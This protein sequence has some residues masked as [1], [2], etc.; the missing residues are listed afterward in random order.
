MIPPALALD[1][2]YADEVRK[3]RPWGYWRFETK[4]DRLTPNE[5]PGRPPLRANGRTTACRLLVGRLKTD[6]EPNIYQVRP[7]V[8]RLDERAV[9]DRPLSPQDIRRHYELG[10]TRRP[11]PR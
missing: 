9:Y 1:P 8:G 3:L 10:T 11:L 6:R 4:A 7:F 5:M 2:A